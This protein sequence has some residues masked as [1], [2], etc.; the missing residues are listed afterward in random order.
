MKKHT[1]W[2]STNFYSNNHKTGKTSVFLFLLFLIFSSYGFSQ[3]TITGTITDE[4]GEPLIGVTIL[5]EGTA[6]GSLSDETGNYSIQASPG[7]TLIYRLAS[8]KTHSEVVPANNSAINVIMVSSH[9]EDMIETGYLSERKANIIGAIEVVDIDD[10]LTTPSASITGQLQGRAT[11]ILANNDGSPGGGGKIRIRG[12]TSLG[13]DNPLYVVDGMPTFDPSGINPNDIASVQILKDASAASI[14]GARA[15]QGVIILTTKKGSNGP[16]R[17]SYD[18]FYGTQTV[19]QSSTPDLLNTE[20]YLGYLQTAYQS[21]FKHPVYG[22]LSSASIPD[23]IIVSPAFRGGV[24]AND[25]RAASELHN[26]S[27]YGNIYQIME[28]SP[29]TDWFDAI[30]RPARLQSHQVSVSG[31]SD[32]SNY[33]FSMNYFDQEG[34][35]EYTDY[36]RYSARI[37][38]SVSPTKWFRAGENFQFLYGK[39]N[40]DNTVGDGGPWALAYQMVPYI[41][42]FDIGGGFGGN[43]VGESGTTPNPLAYLARSKDDYNE[44]YSVFGNTFAEITPAKGLTLRTSFGLS[45]GSSFGR[46]INY[47]TYENAANPAVTTLGTFYNFNL[48]WTLTNTISY[49]NTFGKHQISL[50]G[51][52]EKIRYSGN[53]I[54]VFTYG[55][56]FDDPNFI[57]LNTDQFGTPLTGNSLVIPLTVDSYFGRFN[58]IYAD[59]YLVNAS[60][61]KDGSSRLFRE[62]LTTSFPAL[63]LGWRI[64]QEGFMK[65]AEFIDDLK[66]RFSWGKSGNSIENLLMVSEMT[67]FGMDGSFFKEKL[68]FGLNYFIQNNNNLL[69]AGTTFTPFPTTP[70]PPAVSV[71]YVDMQNKGFEASM[72]NRNSLGDFSYDFTL[73]FTRYVNNVISIGDNPDDFISRNT[74]NLSNVTRT[75]AGQ[76]IAYYYGYE[77][78]GFFET[79]TD[80]NNLNQEGAVTG[81]W[82]FKDQDDN[83]TINFEDQ[84]FLGSPHPDFIMSLNGNLRYKNFDF[85]MFWYWN[86][87]NELYNFSKYFTDLR[88]F[89]GGVSSRVMEN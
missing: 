40:G 49:E 4:Q 78:D 66:L 42:V 2:F 1:Q 44:N 60:I 65:S 87:G 89:V 75:S 57:N 32:R 5:V 23:R 84:T 14:Y 77:I 88:A 37:N 17:L 70:N 15:A 28:T 72:T 50:L 83:Q 73:L 21:S 82:R 9:L 64:S 71:I 63:G 35:Y 11:G 20:E 41:P 24:D 33:L 8:F 54:L 10:M 86:Q 55:F 27:D 85:N 47:R 48:N 81:S 43:G 30:L 45:Y 74:D 12:F 26:L 3:S 52:T 16:I 58:Y 38:S 53:G 31:G 56:D 68:G 13:G 62:D 80:L 61:R 25:P 29:G 79:E 76:P 7:N 46:N 18:G 6:M 36:K 59:K 69:S 67:N 22:F 51:G 39:R 19:P 34:I